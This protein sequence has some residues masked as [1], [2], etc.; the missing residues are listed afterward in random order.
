MRSRASWRSETTQRDRSRPNPFRA[1][2]HWDIAPDGSR[3][4]LAAGDGLAAVTLPARPTLLTGGVAH[5]ARATIDA[6]VGRAAVEHW[7]IA[8]VAAR[9]GHRLRPAVAAGLDHA[10]ETI[11]RDADG[12]GDVTAARMR[13]IVEA[14]RNSA[15][16]DDLTYAQVLG[17]LAAAA[18]DARWGIMLAVDDVHAAH[19]RESESLLGAAA[20]V[21][22]YN[23]SFRSI[24][25][26][27]HRSCVATERATRDTWVEVPL[28]L[29][30]N[31]LTGVL[32]GVAAR[33][34]RCFAPD[35]VA[36]LF[37]ASDGA[38]DFAVDQAALAWT[39]TRDPVISAACVAAAA[40]PADAARTARLRATWSSQLSLGQRRYLRA[41]A[42]HGER[43]AEVEIVAR[44]LGGVTRFGL[45]PS[46]LDGLLTLLV[47]RGLLVV[48]EGM[49]RIAV[50]GLS[51]I[52]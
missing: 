18:A 28:T 21:T 35:A 24:V 41:V 49:A 7:A 42:E 50:P 27:T 25:S 40:E 48:H 37:R 19:R 16:P 4:E 11:A 8:R 22:A 31:A 13:T 30:T 1:P 51:R 14:F 34:D 32:E 43:G 12:N 10:V 6:I 45:S 15:E 46:M 44:D 36:A 20:A 39:S 29:T 5:G 52:L 47:Q 3:L 2:F 33:H 26:A 38:P 23:T 17:A 9:P